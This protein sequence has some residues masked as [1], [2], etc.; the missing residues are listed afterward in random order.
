MADKA[1][2]EKRPNSGEIWDLKPS[3]HPL[4][5][6]ELRWRNEVIY[7]TPWFSPE[8]RAWINRHPEPFPTRP[9]GSRPDMGFTLDTVRYNQKRNEQDEESA[10]LA[11]AILTKAWDQ[12]GVDPAEQVD[13]AS[14]DLAMATVQRNDP[15]WV[16]A[17]L[18]A[19]AAKLSGS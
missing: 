18:A 9:R 4:G 6:A 1:K 2:K 11:K 16:G 10:E 13:S 7:C 12:E 5:E 19:Q 17:R 8:I 15:K 3:F 14:Y